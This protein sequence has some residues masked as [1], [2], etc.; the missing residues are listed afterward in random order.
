[1]TVADQNGQSTTVSSNPDGRTYR[2]VLVV[3]DDADLSVI[4]QA[5]KD[6]KAA[7]PG[8]E[9]SVR[10]GYGSPSDSGA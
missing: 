3:P 2:L 6:F 1:M 7:Y 8:V 4:A 5:V 9:V 10:Q